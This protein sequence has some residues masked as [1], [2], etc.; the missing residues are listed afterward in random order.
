MKYYLIISLLMLLTK[1]INSFVHPVS[2]HNT[3]DFI[4]KKKT[5]KI[6]TI[7]PG[8]LAGFYMLGI[9]T[10]INENY[11]TSEFEILGAS[12]GAWN[13]L[14]MVYK[15][16]INTIVNDILMNYKYVDGEHDVSTIYQ[17]QFNLKKLLLQNYHDDNF[18]LERANIA[19]T[20]I[21]KTG[22]EQVIIS[23]L[24]TLEQA[25][26]CCIASSHIPFISG[27]GVPKINNKR[28]FDGGFDKFPPS[29]LEH[30]LNIS[31]NMWRT[32]LNS[33]L[34]ELL[35]I[36]KLHTFEGFYEQGYYECKQNR[37]IIDKYLLD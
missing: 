4:E 37:N 33:H 36:K 18:D 32:D 15:G 8:G 24:T 20:C 31:P 16:S 3:N 2:L 29:E 14:P 17:L 6:I 19:T 22:F 5:K 26:D 9:I 34:K 25:T 35:N 11:D 27:K 28:L 7:S 30:C 10:Y 21:T 1:H 13:T 12:A 23:N